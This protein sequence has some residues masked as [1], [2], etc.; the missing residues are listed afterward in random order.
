MSR[1]GTGCR[2]LERSHRAMTPGLDRRETLPF[3]TADVTEGAM[4]LEP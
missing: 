3:V 2:R 4:V 1:R